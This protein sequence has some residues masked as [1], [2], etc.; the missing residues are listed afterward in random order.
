MDIIV[1]PRFRDKIPKPSDE[2]LAQLEDNILADGEIRDPLVVWGGK[3]ILIDGHN[4]WAIYQK[5][6][7]ILA[8]PK[9]IEKVFS[10]EYDAEDWMLMNQLGRRNL[11][12]E[13]ASVLRAQVYRTMRKSHGNNAER[14]DDGKYLRTQSGYSG[15][16]PTRTSVLAAKR[17]G[18]G[19]GTIIRDEQ[20]LRGLEAG[21]EVAPGFQDGVLNGSIKVTKSAVRELPKKDEDERK[22]AVEAMK[23]PK[24]KPTGQKTLKEQIAYHTNPDNIPDYEVAD[25]REDINAVLD[26]CIEKLHRIIDLHMDVA[27]DNPKVVLAAIK[28]FETKMKEV[29][30]RV[31]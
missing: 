8:F 31:K 30:E 11:S 17:L 15:E 3:N 16:E 19:K 9:I 4:R 22:V 14:G 6:T 2:E 13:Q 1:D 23:H 26:D 24:Q 7:D 29:K 10:D 20:F 12:A 5:H 27:T 21:D 28:E 25:L 18:V